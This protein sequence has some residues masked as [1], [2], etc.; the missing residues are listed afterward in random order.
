[1]IVSLFYLASTE[2]FLLCN[3][4]SDEAEKKLLGYCFVFSKML[5]DFY[6]AIFRNAWGC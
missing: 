4:F 6:W 2:E 3:E 5:S 1:M